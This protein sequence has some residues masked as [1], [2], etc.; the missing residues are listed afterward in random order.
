VPIKPSLATAKAAV[1][2]YTADQF[3]YVGTELRV[4][5]T[6]SAVLL[7]LIIALYFILR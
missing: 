1:A 4:A 3:K 5:G 6:L 7:V 2:Q